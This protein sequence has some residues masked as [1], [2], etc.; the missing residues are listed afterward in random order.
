MPKFQIT[1][2]SGSLSFGME[3]EQIHGS[4]ELWCVSWSAVVKVKE[5][6]KEEEDE[7][8]VGL[9]VCVVLSWREAA[10]LASVLVADLHRRPKA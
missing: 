3:G 7:I 2:A 5:R 9:S 4:L 1:R 6:E 10:V 8:C